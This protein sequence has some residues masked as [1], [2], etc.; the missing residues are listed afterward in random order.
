[1]S[2]SQNLLLLGKVRPERKRSITGMA[3]ASKLTLISIEEPSSA[4]SWLDSN[5]AHCLIV[6]SSVARLDK[7]VTKLRSKSGQMHVPVFALVQAPDDLW[8]EQYLSWGGDDIVPVDAGAS[9]LER[10]K[11]ISRIEP[12]PC[13]GRSVVVADSEPSRVEGIVRVF[14]QAGYV[15]STVTERDRLE[16]IVKEQSPTVVVAAASFGGLSDVILRL[17][18]YRSKSGWVVL[19]ARR[20]SEN[21]QLALAP[22]ERCVVMGIQS[23]PWQIFYRANE[24]ARVGGIERRR[25]TRWHVGTSV[26]FRAAGSDDDDIGICYN[27]SSSGMFIRTFAPLVANEVWIEWRIPGDKTRVRLEGE[28]V[29]RQVSTS[30]ALRHAAPLGFA[31]RF[32]DY[33]GAGKSHL[34]RAI[35]ALENGGR[36]SSSSRPLSSAVSF[37]SSGLTDGTPVTPSLGK[38]VAS[39][40]GID[41]SIPGVRTSTEP[42]VRAVTANA[43][44]TMVSASSTGSA[45]RP[46][47]LPP[48]PAGTSVV[49][50]YQPEIREAAGER[51]DSSSVL[52]AAQKKAVEADKKAAQTAAVEISSRETATSSEVAVVQPSGVTLP[53]VSSSEL[54]VDEELVVPSEL[55]LPEVSLS[56]LL[57]DDAKIGEIEAPAELEA[58]LSAKEKVTTKTQASPFETVRCDSPIYPNMAVTLRANT[59]EESLRA[60][61][62]ED[63]TIESV[64]H[65]TDR[66]LALLSLAAVGLVGGL[67]WFALHP[68]SSA[69][70]REKRDATSMLPSVIRE[71]A[72]PVTSSSVKTTLAAEAGT[73]E[74]SEAVSVP[75]PGGEI[76]G[77]PPVVESQSGRGR[78]LAER[79][80]YLVVRFPEPAFIFSEAIAI[81][82]VNSKI[83]TT[84]GKKTLRVGVGEKPTTYLS[85]AVEVDIACRDTTRVVFR[86][87]S[88]VE[89]PAGALRPSLGSVTQETKTKTESTSNAGVTTLP[90]GQNSESDSEVAG[91]RGKLPKVPVEKAATPSEEGV[92]NTR[93]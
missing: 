78:L 68:K 25:A 21:E 46:V 66:R 32:T 45:V 2:S 84:C 90:R 51:F 9:L 38:P 72:V 12:K 41:A 50:P 26:L 15:V 47:T 33:L 71:E 67:A 91:S 44:K 24:V 92:V 11:A 70:I 39:A 49:P 82:P 22:L 60:E 10:L 61:L 6:D 29:W 76:A 40:L 55:S 42:Q 35:E 79:Y 74:P 65:R 54:L 3:A 57:L 75:D 62:T 4:L 89:A 59:A 69:P 14:T 83:A 19:A 28:V 5:D 85:N 36:K 18:R 56:G 53:S 30:E 43:I 87:L 31:I 77:Y 63:K 23:S 34:E 27:L 7:I 80:G 37:A 13:L 52:D 93:E 64:K 16:A 1:M 58:T 48:R 20:D 17:R 86:R 73:E 81:G 88:G 8:V